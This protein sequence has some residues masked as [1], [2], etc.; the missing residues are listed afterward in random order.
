MTAPLDI[1]WRADVLF[2]PTEDPAQITTAV[3]TNTIS[4]TATVTDLNGKV[5]SATIEIPVRLTV[6]ASA[7]PSS[8]VAGQSVELTAD[9]RGGDGH[10]HYSWLAQPSVEM[11]DASARRVMSTPSTT[12]TYAVTVSDDRGQTASSQVTIPVMPAPV[13]AASFVYRQPT[14][15][16]VP[17][18]V[19]LD[20]GA[21][22]GNIV[23]YEWDLTWIP[24]GPD[25]I[26]AGPIAT[27]TRTQES[28]RG[29]I[30]LTVRDASGNT[31]T[32]SR[33]YP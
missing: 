3:L 10:Y 22:T 20:A 24:S 31:A 28:L 1:R 13:L 18:D 15:T 33:T 29:T 25:F 11:S 8:V 2:F 9:A 30:T 7:I 27:F 21:S 12:T 16:G 32:T 26:T 5:A 6:S 4:A 17:F 23:A 14:N 19:T